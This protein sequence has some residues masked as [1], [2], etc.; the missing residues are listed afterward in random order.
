MLTGQTRE[1]DGNPL[2]LRTVAGG[3]CRN[4]GA[5]NPAAIDLLAA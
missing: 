1:L 4:A 5:L 2:A 3:A